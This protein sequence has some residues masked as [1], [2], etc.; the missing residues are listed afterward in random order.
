MASKASAPMACSSNISVLLAL[1]CDGV[2]NALTQWD[3]NKRGGFS[4]RTQRLSR[5]ER[6]AA[7]KRQEHKP[8]VRANRSA[9]ATAST[10][11]MNRLARL[12]AR[13]LSDRHRRPRPSQIQAQAPRPHSLS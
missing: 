9:T 1:N 7:L 5:P 10:E 11:K 6:E 3:L 13:L 8:R 12:A 4:T 2:H